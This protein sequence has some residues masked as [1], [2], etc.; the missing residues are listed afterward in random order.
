MRKNVRN[1]FVHTYLV[2]E[3]HFVNDC[4]NT[5]IVGGELYFVYVLLFAKET[6]CPVCVHYC[7]CF[8][9]K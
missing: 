8:A 2:L 1:C 9:Q 4:L 6:R 5:L 3:M 7:V